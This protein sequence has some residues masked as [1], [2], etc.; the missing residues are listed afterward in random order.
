V[1]F[2]LVIIGGGINGAGIARDAAIRG[3][4]VCLVE[5]ADLCS[6]TS[7]WSSRLIHGGLR[8][9]EY[10]ELGLV[11]ECLRERETLLSIAPHLVRPLPMF[12]P[13]YEGARRSGREIALGLWAYD[14]LSMRSS[15]PRHRRLTREQTLS[16]FPALASSGLLSG[17]AYHDAQVTFPERLVVENALAARRAGA[18][19]RLYNHADSIV[20]RDGRVTGVSVTDTRTGTRSML[21]TH[22]VVNASGPWVDEVL[23][24]AAPINSHLLGRSRGSHIV[25]DAIPGLAGSAIYAEAA[26]DG[27]PFFI[28]PWNDQTLIGT[29]DLAFQGDP[30]GV[31]P[32]D[33]EVAYLLGETNRVLPEVRLQPGAVRMEYAGV[34]PLM[35]GEGRKQA[36]VTRRHHICHDKQLAQGLFSVVGGKLTTFRSLAEQVVDRLCKFARRDLLACET[37]SRRLPGGAGDLSLIESE[38]ARNR[39]IDSETI[40]RLMRIYGTRAD[41]VA[42]LVRTK[43]ELG[44]RLGDRTHAIAAEIV[45]GYQAEMA[46]TLADCLF[47]RSMVGLEAGF[48]TT[49]IENALAVARAHF[50]W[51]DNRAN[52][53]RERARREASAL[54]ISAGTA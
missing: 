8:Y 17:A 14:L 46:A 52:A 18:E 29:T 3:F 27:R 19:I 25:V 34:R 36:A 21:E 38:L 15:L 20:V 47:R 11:Y 49:V 9:L 50:D 33:D 35:R 22:M 24:T 32:T 42:R 5:K 23:E 13:I 28:M 41:D 37:A 4:S 31:M 2:D 39:A 53:E 48:D 45:F 1:S 10:G 51:T 7:R 30:G 6:A 43:P 16:E 44:K 40:A 26:A 12:I 54:G